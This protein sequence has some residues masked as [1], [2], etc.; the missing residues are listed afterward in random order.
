MAFISAAERI[1]FRPR[2]WQSRLPRAVASAGPATT[3]SW[4]ASAVNWFR[5]RFLEPP[6]TM[7]TAAIGSPVMFRSESKTRAYL[8][9]KLSS[10]HRMN[11]ACESGIGCAVVE[12]KVKGGGKYGSPACR[13]TAEELMIV[14]ETEMIRL[15]G[16]TKWQ[17]MNTFEKRD[18]V[19]LMS[20]QIAESLG[21]STL[22]VTRLPKSTMLETVVMG[23]RPYAKEVIQAVAE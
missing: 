18:A 3:G 16:A 22:T 1:S 23:I 21:G 17:G 8:R 13:V 10:A 4:Q 15:V 11:S 6:P 9:A 7:F 14:V 2:A 5:S 19:T 20:E 12:S